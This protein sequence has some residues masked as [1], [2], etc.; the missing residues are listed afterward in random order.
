LHDAAHVLNRHRRHRNLHH[1]SLLG[2][3]RRM[4]KVQLIHWNEAEARARIAELKALGHRAAY[5][6]LDG[7]GQMRILA[8]G[9]A[10][11]IVI[12]LSRL[13]SHGRETGMSLRRQK[14]TRL[15]PLV[16]ADG[17]PEKVAR[18]KQ[19]L[20][21]AAYSS[22]K[23]IGSAIHRA[24]AKPVARPVVPDTFAAY[25]GR[26]LCAKLGIKPGM[27]VGL[28]NAP[29]GFEGC[30]ADLPAGVRFVDDAS[31]PRGLTLWFVSQDRD[32][33]KS[34]RRIVSLAKD[35]TVWIAWP[36]KASGVASDLNEKVVRETGLSAGLVDY[37]ICSMNQTWSG[38]AF[39]V[40]KTKLLKK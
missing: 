7:P 16:F 35:A 29:K 14:S 31:E 37:K 21:D 10:D 24:I 4:A 23:Q 39:R 36:K 38:L 26:P 6:A 30:L 34:L 9:K 25:E 22:W 40:R 2:I 1:H 15:I 20:P 19:L 13:P 5:T 28:S 17:E 18:V 33:K 8:E 3:I 32:L 27:V 11:A 12:D